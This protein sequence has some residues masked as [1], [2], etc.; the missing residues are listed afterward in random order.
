[1]A[2]EFVMPKLGLTMESGTI[3][4]WLV[5]DGAVVEPG[6]PVLVIET[7]KVESEVEA[8][9]AG[10]FHRVGEVGEEYPCGAP[11]GWLLEPGEEPPAANAVAAVSAPAVAA[12]AGARGGDRGRPSSQPVSAAT[13]IGGRLLASPNARRLAVA[14]GIDLRSVAGTGPG[15]RITS[16]D[17][18][19]HLPVP[20]TEVASPGS[21]ASTEVASP[22]HGRRPRSRPRVAG[23]DRGRVPRVAAAVG[24]RQRPGTWPSCS[25]S[26]SPRYRHSG[27]ILGSRAKTWRRT[28]GSCW[29]GWP[30]LRPR[31]DR[32]RRPQR[33]VYRRRCRRRCRNRRRWSR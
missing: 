10:R 28:S 13:G 21:R 4:G 6:Q 18:P 30:P 7:D 15:G 20:S 5:D 14:R 12:I 32:G 22:G 29:P 19:A 25:A 17:V 27:S 23:V 16:E 2:D 8:T 11:I 24:H 26:T 31:A 9:K 1:M 33:P 3:V